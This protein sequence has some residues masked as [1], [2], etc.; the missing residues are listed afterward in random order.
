[1]VVVVFTVYN[2]TVM[3]QTKIILVLEHC[4][5]QVEIGRMFVRP[6][7]LIDVT[8]VPSRLTSCKIGSG[9]WGV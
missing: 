3:M 9:G 2:V 5:L 6:I 8:S 4:E 1:M 7:I